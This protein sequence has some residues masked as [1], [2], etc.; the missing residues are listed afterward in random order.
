MDLLAELAKN[1]T[2]RETQLGVLEALMAR[3]K[4]DQDVYLEGRPVGKGWLSSPFGYRTDP[5]NGRRVWHKGI[6]LA[7][8]EG[9]EI[10]AVAAGVVVYAGE[11]RGYGQLVEINHG[12]GYS[13]RYGHQRELKVKAGDVIRKGD[14]VGLM[15][16]TGR[17]T[18]PHVHFEVLKKG[19]AVNPSTYIHRSSQ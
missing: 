19:Q 18:G 5:I 15:G 16:N 13:T 2:Q 14:V 1:I 9:T 6:D 17:S 4:M 10:I 8:K 11:R 7:G 3:R 12:S